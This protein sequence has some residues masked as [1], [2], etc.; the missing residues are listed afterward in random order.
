[1]GVVLTIPSIYFTLPYGVKVASIFFPLTPS[2]NL[3]IEVF[4]G[5]QVPGTHD[6]Q[7]VGMANPFNLDQQFIL[8]NLSETS[9]QAYFFNDN[10]M[11]YNLFID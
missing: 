5:Q 3:C 11:L 8:Y 4:N 6:I 1:M 10:A 7:I 2:T 9:S